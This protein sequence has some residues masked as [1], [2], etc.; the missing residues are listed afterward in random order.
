MKRIP[1]ITI[2]PTIKVQI[3]R[4]MACLKVLSNPHL[5]KKFQNIHLQ[6][7]ITIVCPDPANSIYGSHSPLGV[8]VE[9]P[10][11]TIHPICHPQ[12]PSNWVND[13]SITTIFTTLYHDD[14]ALGEWTNQPML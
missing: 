9:L 14:N 8:K 5:P 10:N 11:T 4:A 13:P 7:G 6:I 3:L 1:L 12:D 2:T